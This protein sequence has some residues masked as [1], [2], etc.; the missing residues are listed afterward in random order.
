MEG[1]WV[2]TGKPKQD[3]IARLFMVGT[4]DVSLLAPKLRALFHH[5]I[6]ELVK[7]DKSVTLANFVG[8]IDYSESGE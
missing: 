7:Q 2:D 4:A 5:I 6:T 1:L 8:F 3:A